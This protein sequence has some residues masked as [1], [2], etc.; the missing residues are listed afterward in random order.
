ME[1]DI[2]AI[3]GELIWER[4]A[5]SLLST[6]RKLRHE[7]ADVLF[8]FCGPGHG[9]NGVIIRRRARR[10]ID[11]SFPKA[12]NGAADIGRISRPVCRT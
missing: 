6:H 3:P 9:Q 8:E 1:F 2:L 7:A 5:S 4:I 11:I 10:A 12:K